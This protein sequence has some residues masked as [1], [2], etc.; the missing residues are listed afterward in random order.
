MVNKDVIHAKMDRKKVN[1]RIL[2][3]DS[4]LEFKKGESQT[5]IEV[6]KEDDWDAI[7]K[8]EEDYVEALCIEIIKHKPDVIFCEKGVSNLAQHYLAEAGISVIRRIRKWDNNRIARAVGATIVNEP[9][10][11]TEANIGKGCGLFEVKKIGDEY[12]TYL[13]ECKNPKACTILLRGASK[14][15][16]NEMER[17]LH[18]AMGVVKTLA[19]N[20]AIVPGGGCA[21]MGMALK[22][23]QEAKKITGLARYAFEAVGESMEVIPR[24]LIENCGGS[25]VRLLTELRAKHATTNDAKCTFGVD[26]NAGKVVDMNEISVFDP[27]AVKIQTIKTAIESACMLLR[28]DD[29]VSGMSDRNAYRTGVANSEENEEDQTFGDSRDG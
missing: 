15:V 11:I 22:I 17:N 25:T 4:P 19:L 12:F 7:L 2:L 8:A 29:V 21:E 6:S 9:S 20:P 23:S 27:Y 1:P 3:L 10:E 5:N 13:L 16:L 18:D 26:G 24:T 28:I 14:D